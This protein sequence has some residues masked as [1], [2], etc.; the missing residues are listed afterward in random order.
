LI[1]FSLGLQREFSAAIAPWLADLTKRHPSLLGGPA[2][3]S[4]TPALC[5]R[6]AEP[7]AIP[8]GF[9]ADMAYLGGTQQKLAEAIMAVPTLVGRAKSL[10]T[11]R[12][13]TLLHLLLCRELRLISIWHPSFLTL[14]LD[15]LPS[16][17]D[18][19]IKDVERGANGTPACPERARELRAADPF[20]FEVLWPKLRVISC[21]GDGAA[22]FALQEL[23][24][25]FPNVPL[26][27]KGL[28][29]TEA[30]V[31]LPFAGHYPLAV[32]SHFFEFIDDAG[33]VH[34][35]ETLRENAEYEI[36][37]TTSGGLWRYR[38]GD[39]VRVTGWLGNTPSLRF[40]GRG[41]SVSDRCGEKLSEAFVAETFRNVF[42]SDVSRFALL[43]PDE[44]EESCRYTLY[45]EGNVK[46]HWRSAMESALCR[47]PHYAYCRDLQQLLYLRIFVINHGGYETFVRRQLSDGA[48]LGDIKPAALSRASGWSRLFSGEYWDKSGNGPKLPEADTVQIP[49]ALKSA[50]D[51][52]TDHD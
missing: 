33:K 20:Q 49:T 2:Y 41:Q 4:I 15:A 50:V 23:R 27:P 47:N 24:R 3:W 43:A 19:L 45:I 35:V 7:S 12:Y 25:R 1:P 29:A 46:S 10:E 39:R 5:E 51:E 28:I 16:H 6:T 52:Q 38:L 44:D 26:L 30:F 14:L 40:M 21:W 11:F 32:R 17:W 48:R 36:V 34:C 22:G 18:K 42:C 9:D 13:Q 8:I 31:T 37:V